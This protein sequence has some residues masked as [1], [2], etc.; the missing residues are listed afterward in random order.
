MD[1]QKRYEIAEKIA[2]NVCSTMK[3]DR[4]KVFP[5]KFS[6]R[7][8]KYEILVIRQMAIYLI[9][10]VGKLSLKDIGFWCCMHHTTIMHAV[11]KISGLLKTDRS[12]AYKIRKCRSSLVLSTARR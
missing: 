8:R 7:T 11:S 5:R 10:I 12:V 4:A 3:V 6:D 1:R 9:R 2:T